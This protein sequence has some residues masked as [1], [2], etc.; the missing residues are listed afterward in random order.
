MK[1][2][3]NDCYWV[4]D[5]KGALMTT[6]RILSRNVL[7]FVASILLGLAAWHF[8][9]IYFEVPGYVLPK[10]SAAWAGIPSVEPAFSIIWA[11]PLKLPLPALRSAQWWAWW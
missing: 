4:R 6:R 3:A 8:G 11:I 7:P 1:E 10:P 5:W 9:V 2:P